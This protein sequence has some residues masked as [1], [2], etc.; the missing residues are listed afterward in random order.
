MAGLISHYISYAQFSGFL[1]FTQLHGYT[2]EPRICVLDVHTYSMSFGTLYLLCTIS[3][4][5]PIFG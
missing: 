3:D 2:W 1:V 5:L 4:K